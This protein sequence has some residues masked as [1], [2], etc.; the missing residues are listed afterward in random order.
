[1][2]YAFSVPGLFLSYYYMIVFGAIEER[3]WPAVIAIFSAAINI[4]FVIIFTKYMG[5]IGTALASAI[6]YTISGIIFHY[7]Y[8]IYKVKNTEMVSTKTELAA[9]K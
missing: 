6:S 4:L 7:A 5:I 2:I 3:K 9:E 1:M 8:K